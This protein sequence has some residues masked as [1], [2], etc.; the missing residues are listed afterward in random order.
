MEQI[1]LAAQL[2]TILPVPQV[3]QVTEADLGRS[4]RYYPLVGLA[5]GVVLAAAQYLLSRRLA[6]IP[7]AAIVLVLLVILSGALH[8][9]GVADVCDGFYK[10]KDKAEILA[11]MKDSHCGAMA[12]V[13][14]VCLFAL[15]LAFLSSL[16]SVSAWKAALLMPVAGRWG[17]VLLAAS[18]PYARGEGTA[19]AYVDHA[20]FTEALIAA[21]IAAA[22][23]GAVIG[24]AGLIFLCALSAFT[25]AFRQYAISKIGG[26]TGDVLG[27]CGEFNECAFL[28]LVSL[29]MG[30]R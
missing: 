13:G 7:T 20:G 25:L 30:A 26:V 19:K 1:Y 4:M 3:R 9:D 29:T 8:W 23:M 10:G 5:M 14:I 11:I 16:P 21:L 12:I 18:A 15:K 22:A 24:T 27:A 17:M 6:E 2:L 28:L